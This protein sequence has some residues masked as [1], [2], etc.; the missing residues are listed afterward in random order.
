MHVRNVVTWNTVICGLVDCR[1]S[2][3]ESSVYRCFCYFRKMLL[4]KV[5][6]DAITLN[7]LLRACLGLNDVEIGRELHCLIVKL[8]FAVNSFVSSALVDMYGKCGLVK[9]ARR[10]FDE[11]YCRDLVLWNVMLSCYAMNCLAEEASGFFKLMQKEN[12]LTDGFTFSSMLNSCR[13]LGACDLGR[14]IHGLAIR[15]SFDLDV[16]VASGLVDMY[17]KSENID[18]ARKAF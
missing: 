14:Q 3:Y 17:A 5:G 2:G 8:G 1:G 4:D 12:F 15:L 6:F 10:A 9:E 16:L 11:V 18:D 13:T 7:G